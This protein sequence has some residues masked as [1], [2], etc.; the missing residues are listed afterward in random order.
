MP[1]DDRAP[2]AS[3][4]VGRERMAAPPLGRAAAAPPVLTVS[5]LSYEV[6]GRRILDRVSFALRHG[7]LVVVMGPSGTGKTTL[8][9][10]N[11]LIE[12]T[13]G[14]V[15][16]EGT[17]TASLSP[18][19]LRRRI[20]MVWQTPFMFEGSVRDNLR[21]AAAYAETTLDDEAAARLLERVA[22]DRGLEDDARRLSLGQQQRVAMAPALVARP[23][24]LLCDEPT[25]SRDEETSLRLEATLRELCDA[26]M[27]MLFVTHDAAQAQRIADRTLRLEAARLT[28]IA[29]GSPPSDPGP[30]L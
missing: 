9:C 27:T 8:K 14:R 15:E 23:Q 20:G 12:P 10:R 22:F 5:D 18:A 28:E 2:D 4:S 17:D 24:I 16:I 26:G 29:S 19:R 3:S 30:P 1:V 21:R 11:R 25:A 7:E 13:G 6:D